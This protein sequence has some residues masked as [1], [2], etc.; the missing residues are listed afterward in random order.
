MSNQAILWSMAIVPWFTIFFMKKEDIK[1]FMPIAF[2]TI[3]CTGFVI[4]AGNTL[5]L[6]KVR[7][8]IYPLNQTVSYVYGLAPVVAMWVFKFTYGRIWL[9]IIG[10]LVF[11]IVFSFLMVPW[12]AIQGIKDLN[13]SSLTVLLIATVLSIP[14]YLYQMWQEDAL[15]PSVKRF[16]TPK[17]QSALNKPLIKE[18]DKTDKK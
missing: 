6:W 14:L 15:V 7:E 8:T 4:E 11:N 18:D 16:F 2:L 1:R 5:N 17:I 9:F 3:V 10:D 13:V 12:L